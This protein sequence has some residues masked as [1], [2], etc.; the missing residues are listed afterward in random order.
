MDPHIKAV[1][2]TIPL[3]F[4]F[5]IVGYGIAFV[6]AAIFHWPL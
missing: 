3:M 2:K 1:L 5:F 6:L 4:G